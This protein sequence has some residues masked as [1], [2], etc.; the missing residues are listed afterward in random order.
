MDRKQLEKERNE[1]FDE[2]FRC[3]SNDIE[4]VKNFCKYLREVSGVQVCNCQGSTFEYLPQI[5]RSVINKI[6]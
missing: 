2:E 3:K 4:R 5:Y 6:K 1:L